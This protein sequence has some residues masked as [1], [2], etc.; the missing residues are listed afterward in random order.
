MAILALIRRNSNEETTWVPAVVSDIVPG[1]IY[2]L[3]V[4]GKPS[5]QVCRALSTPKPVTENFVVKEW[6]IEHEIVPFV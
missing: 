4:N 2:R 1:D 6:L 5:D 3:I